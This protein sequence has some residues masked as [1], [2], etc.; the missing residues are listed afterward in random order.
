[1][2]KPARFQDTDFIFQLLDI[3]DLALEK[4]Q[5]QQ[6]RR[7]AGQ[8]STHQCNGVLVA[9]GIETDQIDIRRTV[10]KVDDIRMDFPVI[11]A[12][13]FCLAGII[14]I[15]RIVDQ[16]I[17]PENRD[18][19]HR[20]LLGPVIQKFIVRGRYIILID[21]CLQA[22]G[23]LLLFAFHVSGGL[24]NVVD[25]HIS[26]GMKTEKAGDACRDSPQEQKECF[27]FQAVDFLIQSGI[28]FPRRFLYEADSADL[29]QP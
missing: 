6:Q 3:I 13:G 19:D 29:F 8:D 1:M 2:V 9:H 23:A 28:P 4:Q 24:Q 15:L 25:Q 10:G 27:H 22:V 11:S 5:D 16:G 7:A 20:L 12:V 26:Q 14:G 18:I 17:I 21:E